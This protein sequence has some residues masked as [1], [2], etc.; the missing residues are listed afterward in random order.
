VKI[1]HASDLHLGIRQ[2]ARLNKSGINVRESDVA[3]S[4]ERVIGQTIAIA[5]EMMVIAGDVFHQSKPSNLSIKHAFAQFARLRAALPDLE[6][7]L[8][9]GNHDVNRTVELGS[10]LGLFRN[11][12]VH[13]VD[14]PA[15][16]LDFPHLDCEV[17]AVPDNHHAR[18]TLEPS[19]GRTY[20]LLLLHG[21]AG[22]IGP[23]KEL[24]DRE[25]TAEDLHT[26]EWSYVAM[27]HYHVYR[28]V[29]PNCAYSGGIDYTT[30]N[31]WGERAEEIEQ[32]LAGKGI[33]ERD[34]STGAQTFHALPPTRLIRDLTPIEAQG[35]AVDALNDAIRDA[36]ESV[37]VDG[38]VLR[39]KVTGLPRQNKIVRS[40]LD[41]R[42]LRDYE[43]RALN[44]QIDFR[45]E[46]A[47]ERSIGTAFSRRI[48]LEEQV[49]TLLRARP[50]PA[51]VDRELFISTGADYIEKAR[52]D[53]KVIVAE[54]LAVG[55]AA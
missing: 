48:P 15:Q 34:L 47:K 12:G 10:I 31:I 27:G 14:G 32:G 41:R 19:R 25:L 38:A 46:D 23:T 16:R 42:M 33:V 49:A 17:L 36:L 20:N 50:L 21:E 7:C 26:P 44:L 37:D 35:M 43:R 18:P 5:P 51:D 40:M 13:V 22:G 53:N 4:F 30:S 52:D 28:E 6:V 1:V 54:E 45:A 39:L 3:R 55:V 8:I 24:R 29:A 9:S 11:L 2:F